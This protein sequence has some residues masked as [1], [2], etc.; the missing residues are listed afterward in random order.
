MKTFKAQVGGLVLGAAISL[1][2]Y[3]FLGNKNEK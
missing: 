2:N 1:L 3:F